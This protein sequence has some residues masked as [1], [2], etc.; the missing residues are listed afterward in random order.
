LFLIFAKK[1]LTHPGKNFPQDSSLVVVRVRH[2]GVRVC[3][4]NTKCIEKF[5]TRVRLRRYED[6][7]LHR[8]LSERNAEL[9]GLT[10]KT[11]KLERLI[12]LL[13][14]EDAGEEAP[15][16]RAEAEEAGEE[17]PAVRAEAG[18]REANGKRSR[19][20]DPPAARKRF[21]GAQRQNRARRTSPASEGD[22]DDTDM[23]MDL[24][25][26]SRSRQVAARKKKPGKQPKQQKQ[27]SSSEGTDDGDDEH[28]SG[29]DE[30]LYDRGMRLASQ[31][32]HLAADYRFEDMTVGSYAVT[33][34]GGEAS[35][36]CWFNVML[37]DGGKSLPLH[38][39]E[40]VGQHASRKEITWQ[41]WLPAQSRRT[42]E[43]VEQLCEAGAF[44]RGARTLR[45]KSTFDVNE[46]L[47]CWDETAKS[48]VQGGIPGCEEKA[49]LLKA[50]LEN[51]EE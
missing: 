12:Q 43:T 22:S 11:K 14:A 50:L 18:V 41:F 27:P 31:K 8:V 6:K 30:S 44:V 21:S 7:H 5:Q 37:P 39:V 4:D 20:G 28:S 47:T 29:V 24:A 51:S 17:A 45:M 32:E 42:F 15:A 13:K 33:V 2:C 16:V 38:F 25:T 26:R 35:D 23:E 40:V 10:T 34:A 19:R 3:E 36:K 46:V 49:E 1:T 48:G 9:R